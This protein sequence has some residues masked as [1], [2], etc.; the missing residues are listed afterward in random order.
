MTFKP[1]FEDFESVTKAI[2]DGSQVDQLLVHVYEEGSDQ[3]EKETYDITNCQVQQEVKIPFYYGKKYKV[4]FWAYKSGDDS[5]YTILPNGLKGGVSVNYP[6]GAIDF[7]ALDVTKLDG[8]EADD[9]DDLLKEFEDANYN[10][11]QR[12]V[13]YG[14]DYVARTTL[15][16]E[17]LMALESEA[18]LDK[19]RGL[20][21]YQHRI[22]YYGT[23]S[24]RELAKQLNTSHVVAEKL[25][26]V[27]YKSPPNVE[28]T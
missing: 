20:K 12:Y 23:M 14:S 2:G 6:G 18:L 1:K 26:P 3:F 22:L 7:D 27:E 11:L 13:V 15:T 4:Y 19:I 24:K 25:I 10:A 16:N 9:L 21:N 5:P 28:V 8:V 17:Q